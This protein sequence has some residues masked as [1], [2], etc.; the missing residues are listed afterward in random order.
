MKGVNSKQMTNTHIASAKMK[1]NHIQNSKN[2]S[3]FT[4][5]G[6][7]ELATNTGRCSS[8]FKNKN[9]VT[10]INRTG[11]DSKNK[12]QH[13]MLTTEENKLK[14]SDKMKIN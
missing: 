9:A 6:S 4:V 7:Q 12:S 10:T 8:Y 14:S 11:E 13:Q 1:N 5:Y 3:E 2:V